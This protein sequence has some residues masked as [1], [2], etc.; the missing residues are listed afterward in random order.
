MGR[1]VSIDHRRILYNNLN[2][3]KK[4]IPYLKSLDLKDE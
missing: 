1:Q 2:L 4:I 3:K